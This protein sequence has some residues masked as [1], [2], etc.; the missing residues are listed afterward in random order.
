MLPV[1]GIAAAMLFGSTG[2]A[3]VYRSSPRQLEGLTYMGTDGAPSEIVYITATGYYLLWSIPLASG[4]LCWNEETRSI[5]G[6]TCFFR[7]QVGTTELQ[8]AL[9]K[10]ADTCNCDVLDVTFHDSDT[11]YAGVSTGGL[12]GALFGSSQIGVS[13]V[14]VPRKEKSQVQEGG[15]E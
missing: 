8:I 11:T 13:G 15:L 9:N 7:D 1:V 12:I 10:I 14:F 5:N 3:T 6:G 2:C 4:D